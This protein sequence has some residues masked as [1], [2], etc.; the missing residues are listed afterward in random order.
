MYRFIFTIHHTLR[1]SGII[2]GLKFRLQNPPK[3]TLPWSLTWHC[4]WKKLPAPNR[5]GS[6]SF[7]TI[8][9]CWASISAS[10]V[11]FLVGLFFKAQK[12]HTIFFLENKKPYWKTRQRDPTPGNGM[13]GFDEISWIG[14]KKAY[15]A[16]QNCWFHDWEGWPKNPP[17]YISPEF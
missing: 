3:T 6:S 14:A 1:V 15:F 2:E 17:M 12:L 11:W 9:L 10:Q 13:L 16:R 4:P 7:P 5:K 8:L